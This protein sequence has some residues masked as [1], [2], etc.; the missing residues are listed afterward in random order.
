MK[1]ILVVFMHQFLHIM[2][3]RIGVAEMTRAEAIET[4]H[5]FTSWVYLTPIFGALLADSILGKYRT[6]LSLSIVYCFGH[7]ALAFMGMGGMSAES[8]L[9]TGLLLIA[10]GSGESNCV[11]AHVGDQFGKS[12]GHW[13]SK[14]FGWFYIS[15]NVGAFLSTLSTPLLLEYYG[16]RT[17]RSEFPSL[18]GG[19]YRGLLDG[20]ACFCPHPAIGYGAFQGDVQSGGVDGTPEAREYFHLCRRLLG[21][22]LTKPDPPGC[23]RRRT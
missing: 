10:V 5:D 18:D 6:I 14:V 16:P 20:P 4:Y 21:P 9:M 1:A 12:N 23:F 22:S 7:L 2:D 13:L 17:G 8:W 11:S 19:C 3:R 15:I